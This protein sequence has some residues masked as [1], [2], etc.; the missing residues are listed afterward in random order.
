MTSFRLFFLD[1][2]G[3]SL[4]LLQATTVLK[5]VFL[6]AIS[7]PKSAQPPAQMLSQ[8]ICSKTDKGSTYLLAFGWSF[9]NYQRSSVSYFSNLFPCVFWSSPEPTIHLFVP[10][11]PGRTPS[12]NF[13]AAPYDPYLCSGTTP[14]KPS[15]GAPAGLVV[16]ESL[17]RRYTSPSQGQL[18]CSPLDPFF[19]FRMTLQP[20]PFPQ[21]AD[22]L[23]FFFRC[24]F[25]RYAAPGEGSLL[26]FSEFPWFFPF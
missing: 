15:H 12:P 26:F 6:I 25:S 20:E 7:P 4:S 17:S 19:W 23:F 13:C 5:K 10:Y 9:F 8:H 1:C 22:T 14:E 2:P 16:T 21:V 24:F 18:T 11:S 3:D